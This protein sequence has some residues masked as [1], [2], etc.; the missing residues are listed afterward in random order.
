M[1]C[2][3]VSCKREF[4]QVTT[5]TNSSTHSKSHWFFQTGFLQFR[6]AAKAPHSQTREGDKGAVLAELTWQSTLLALCSHMMMTLL[7]LTQHMHCISEQSGNTAVT[8]SSAGSSA[9][10]GDVS[11]TQEICE[12][13]FSDGKG[14]TRTP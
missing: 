11:I 4:M 14:P 5:T 9:R 6:L 3:L 8:I 12:S 2:F 13:D 1:D 10:L 7:S